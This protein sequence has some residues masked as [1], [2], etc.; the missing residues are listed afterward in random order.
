VALEELSTKPILP[1]PVES[2]FLDTLFLPFDEE[3][4]LS[5]S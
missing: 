5:I 4:T 3:G 1:K 2:Q